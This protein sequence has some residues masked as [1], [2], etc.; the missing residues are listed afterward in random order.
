[1]E[2]TTPSPKARFLESADNI[3][4]HRSMVDSKEFQ[5]ACDFAMLQFS[6]S[7]CQEIQD[8]NTAMAVGMKLLGANQ[9]M[10]VLR[11][12]SEVPKGPTNIITP[13]LNHQA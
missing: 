13:R 9:F 4:K 12:L 10:Q 8:G 7:V 1:M 2:T 3:S 6:A 11:N 5:R